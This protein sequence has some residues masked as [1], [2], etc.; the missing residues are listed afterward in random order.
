MVYKILCVEHFKWLLLKFF[1]GKER[2]RKKYFKG[3]K[4]GIAHFD[5][6]TR[7]SEFG[8]LAAFLAI[9]I[10]SFYILLSFEYTNLIISF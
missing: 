4:T 9:E 2:Y 8:H 3:T 5:M 10:T 6:Q 7:Q 1:W